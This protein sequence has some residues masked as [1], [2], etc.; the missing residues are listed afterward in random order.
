MFNRSEI[1]KAAWTHYRWVRASYADWQ[2]AR[3]I[4]D[5]SF[6]NALR[7]AWRQAK[8]QSAKRAVEAKHGDRLAALR[9]QIDF[10]AYKPSH[11]NIE[12]RRQSLEREI[13]ALAG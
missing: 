6:A 7:V 3:G 2:I 11:I 12:R 1:M 8:E 13:V 9:S 5:G 10:L 4:V